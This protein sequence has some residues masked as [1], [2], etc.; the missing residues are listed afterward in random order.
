MQE[1]KDSLSP[2][3]APA[4]EEQTPSAAQPPVPSVS[5]PSQTEP[6]VLRYAQNVGT[7]WN[8]GVS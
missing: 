5:S 1:S 3:P 6:V 4:P 8:Y 7:P 2:C